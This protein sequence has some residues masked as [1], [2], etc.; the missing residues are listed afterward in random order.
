M[1]LTPAEILTLSGLFELA[2]ADR[3][4]TRQR[5]AEHTGLWREE[6]AAASASLAVGGWLDPR[7]LRLTLPGLCLAAAIAPQARQLRGAR[8]LAA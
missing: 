1:R 5:L 2:Q 8:R 7:E 3:E 6:V 4:A